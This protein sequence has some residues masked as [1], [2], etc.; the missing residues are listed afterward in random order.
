MSKKDIFFASFSTLILSTLILLFNIQ[1]GEVQPW[2]EGLYAYRAREILNTNLWW[3]QT[4]VSLGGLYSSTYPPLVPW[5]MAINMKIFGVNLFSIRLLSVLCS[6]FTIFLFIYFFSK[7]FELQTTFLVGLNLLLTSHWFLYS[8]QGMTD[9]PLLFFI[10]LNILSIAKFLESSNKFHKKF[11]GFL[12]S[13]TFSLALMTKIV[14]SFIPLLT[15]IFVAKYFPKEVT[16]KV[17]L[18]YIIGLSIALPWYFYMSITYGASFVSAL[19]P[20]HLFSVVEG[21]YKPLGIFYYINQLLVSNPL[22]T[23]AFLNTYFRI[24]KKNH[25][26]IFFSRNF[27]SD[28]FFFWFLS[29]LIIFS[30]APTKL[31]HYTLYIQLP[32][33]YLALE[34]ISILFVKLPPTFRFFSILIFTIDI[35]WYFSPNFRQSL[36]SLEFVN[37]P[38]S[39]IVLLASL[40]LMFFIYIMEKKIDDFK[41]F[42]YKTLPSLIFL[43]SIILIFT[44]IL[45]NSRK[46]VGNIFG[47]EKT[48]KILLKNKESSFVYVFHKVN[49]SDTLNPQLAW[50][51]N[52]LFFGKDKGKKIYF[53]PIPMNKIGLAEIKKVEKFPNQMIIYYIHSNKIQRKILTEYILAKRKILLVTP[54]YIVFGKQERFGREIEQIEI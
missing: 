44:T 51:T 39:V 54:N 6:S 46:P 8:R 40:S 20:P 24:F 26:T 41:F 49:N 7:L 4:S 38:I 25:N 21:N 13:F 53:I 45:T 47:G 52:G 11:Y 23:F 37:F 14:L 19:F 28:I 43:F 15:L 30:L 29:A 34:F 2:D 5:L 18:Y 32:A 9:I 50:Y 16:K 10:F 12:I 1:K 31:P 48:A 33:F 17:I 35:F 27:L 42:S 3:D 22:L 36:Q